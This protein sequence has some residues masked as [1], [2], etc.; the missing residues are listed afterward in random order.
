MSSIT[1]QSFVDD[2][3]SFTKRVPRGLDP[4]HVASWIASNRSDTS[5]YTGSFI[6]DGADMHLPSGAAPGFGP[7]DTRFY[8]Q[9]KRKEPKDGQGIAW[10]DDVQKAISGDIQRNLEKIRGLGALE[11]KQTDGDERQ[12]EKSKKNTVTIPMPPQWGTFVI[13]A[14]DGRV[15]VVDKDGEFDSGPQ[16]AVSEEP[17]HWVKAAPPVETG[18]PI[19]GLTPRSPPEHRTASRQANE[20]S[21]ESRKQRSGSESKD[22]HKECRR[23][24]H[25]SP[26]ILTPIPE[27]DYEEGYLLSGG[28]D[29]GSP[30]DFMMTG[31]ASGWPSSRA[32]SVASPAVS[33]SDAY[34]YVVPNSPI[35]AISKGFRH[36]APRSQG[37]KYVVPESNSW[38]EKK[39]SPVR[40]PPGGWPSPELSPIKGDDK[41]V[42]ERSWDGGQSES[43]WKAA[44]PIQS[45]KSHRSHHTSKSNTSQKSRKYPD[46]S[47]MK[48]HAMYKA[49]TVED[50]SNSSSEEK[51]DCIA[52]GWGGSVKSSGTQGW[53]GDKKDSENSFKNKEEDREPVW[54]SPT[55][56]PHPHTWAGAG[57]KSPSEQSWSK[58]PKA[59]DSPSWTGI[60]PSAFQQ[61]TNSPTSVHFGRPTRPSSDTTWDGFE[62]DKST[63]EVGVVG[64]GS[65]RTSLG[66][67]SRVSS[68]KSHYSH[69]THASR[70]SSRHAQPTGWG[71]GQSGWAGGSQTSHRSR[72]SHRPDD[73][74]GWPA[75]RA[76]SEQSWGSQKNRVNDGNGDEWVGADQDAG[77]YANEFDE[78][79]ATYLNDNWGG[80][81][82]RVGGRTG[83]RSSRQSGATAGWE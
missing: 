51:E 53:G 74:A 47:S 50:A 77:K 6:D 78:D 3:G 29:T 66:H 25:S 68:R 9:K 7:I 24:H 71:D 54:T 36:V 58:R 52:T 33:V 1:P 20:H 35:E 70:R 26:K 11:V 56:T 21:K 60:D 61:T 75:S 17:K 62:R 14:D 76:A 40:S 49:P 67:Q 27:S 19:R 38:T 31:G 82:V 81:P 16:K 45:H 42:L 34:E 10:N 8:K 15:I 43:A 13:K 46:G 73:T 12:D 65:E 59:A 44:N 79:N 22:K 57:S 37:Y 23:S 39:A 4:R 2:G 63:S 18:S 64:T 5:A 83:S 80:T 72:H 41:T 69:G 55:N 28:K 48:S 32:T 30:T